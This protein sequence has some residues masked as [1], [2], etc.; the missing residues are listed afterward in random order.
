V[1]IASDVTLGANVHIPQ[2][3]LVNLF[4]CTIGEK[5]LIGPF[6]EIQAGAV[7]G[8]RCKVS[9]HSF[10]CTGVEIEDGVFIG[11]GVTFTNDRLPRSTND[12]GTL[13][14]GSDWI[15]ER[16]FVRARA[17][18]GSG[19]TIMCGL[20]IGEQALVGAGAVVTKNVPA[21]AIV[22]G[23][24]ARIIGDVRPTGE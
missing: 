24:P 3:D 2:P 7:V 17:S 18:I 13:K 4:G 22:A 21:F 9:S 14:G 12:D 8:R 11:H 1:A 5:S 16:T 23:N 20:E 10:I 19:A 6:V 15:L